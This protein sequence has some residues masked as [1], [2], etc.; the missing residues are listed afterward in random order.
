LPRRLPSGGARHARDRGVEGT[1]AAVADLAA[2][3]G[4][5]A[6]LPQASSRALVEGPP[7]GCGHPAA[8]RP[9]VRDQSPA[10]AHQGTPD[11][12]T[13]PLWW[14]AALAL[15]TFALALVLT[16]LVRAWSLR[17]GFVDHPGT[18]K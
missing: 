7:D 8:L 16:P 5:D 15:G 17:A 10:R 9:P 12:V 6:L 18:R 11:K 4:D 13:F 14:A 2:A 3:R 1:A